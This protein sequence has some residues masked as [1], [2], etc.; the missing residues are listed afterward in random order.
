MKEKVIISVYNIWTWQQSWL[1]DLENIY[2]VCPFFPKRLKIKLNLIGQVVSEK[3]EII[4]HIHV[5]STGQGQTT[6][7]GNKNYKYKCSVN[8]SFAA[9]FST[10]F[11][12]FVTVFPNQIHRRPNL[13]LP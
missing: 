2:N 9:S 11:N 6:P 13:T 3:F 4:G 8:W 10:S 1:C 12:D 7:W 5:Y